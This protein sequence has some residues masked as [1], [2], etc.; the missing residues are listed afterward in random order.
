MYDNQGVYTLISLQKNLKHLQFISYNYE[1][2]INNCPNLSNSLSYLSDTLVSLEFKEEDISYLSSKSI[3]SLTKLKSLS[4]DLGK[5]NIFINNHLNSLNLIVLPFLEILEITL[6]QIHSLD[7]FIS[8]LQKTKYTIKKINID[9]NTLII[10]DMGSLSNYIH[11]IIA[12]CPLIEKLNLWVT[13]NEIGDTEI[14]LSS[15]INLKHLKLEAIING[16]D[17]KKVLEANPF[18]E[19]FSSRELNGLKEISLT[20]KWNFNNKGLENFLIESEKNENFGL[21]IEFHCVNDNDK[22]VFEEICDKYK[23]NGILKRYK[24]E[25][26]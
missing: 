1:F 14:L 17:D 15:C 25:I 5:E 8:L 21:G 2:N 24:F 7:P 20:G 16:D 26:S 22:E 3:N 13:D 12:Y 18:L 19:L 4:I 6:S 9:T 23:E 10:K 11:T